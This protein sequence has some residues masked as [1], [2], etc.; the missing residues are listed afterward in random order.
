MVFFFFFFS[1]LFFSFLLLIFFF[2]FMLYQFVD[3]CFLC[4]I[5]SFCKNVLVMGLGP[6]G[7]NSDPWK[8]WGC[9]WSSQCILPPSS[10]LPM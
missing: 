1:S 4:K 2:L 9:T 10:G 8:G 3:F 5:F 7:H 6:R